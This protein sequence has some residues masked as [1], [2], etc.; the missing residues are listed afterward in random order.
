MGQLLDLDEWGLRAEQLL[1]LNNPAAV[2]IS[3]TW[4]DYHTLM[5]YGPRERIRRIDAHYRRDYQRLRA[6]LPAGELEL[7][8]TPRRPTGVRLRLPLDELPRLL[9]QDFIGS[10]LVQDIVGMARVKQEAGPRFWCVEARFAVQIENATKGLQLYEDRMLLVQAASEVE[11]KQKLMTGFEGYAKPYLN[12][13]GQLVRWQFES[14]LDT[15]SLD[16]HSASE[17]T[18]EQGVEVFSR[19]KRRRLRPDGEWHPGG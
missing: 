13:S 18:N 9:E 6:A 16:V 19:L 17:F 4:P 11:A 5:P 2:H 15:Y 10:I 7:T 3:L 14:F 8:G 12:N 1:G